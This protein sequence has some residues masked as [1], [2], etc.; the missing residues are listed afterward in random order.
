MKREFLKELG[1]EA[2]AIDKIM[3]ENGKDIENAKGSSEQQTA[4][5]KE[6]E[7]ENKSLKDTI[8][9]RDKQLEGLTKTA[10]DNEQLKAQIEQLTKDNKAAAE[11]HEAEMTSLRKNHA[12]ESALIEAKAKA[13]KAVSAYIDADQVSFDSKGNI[14]G[15]TE[16]INALKEADDTKFLFDSGLPQLKGATPGQPSDPNDNGYTKKQI[17]AMPYSKQQ[18]IH[19]KDPEAWASIMGQ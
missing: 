15:L 19:D 11:R 6:L 10:G 3:A 2:E 4:K 17:L 16:Q 1:I 14:I 7:A 13:V 18:E 9:E 8:S 5:V 12:I